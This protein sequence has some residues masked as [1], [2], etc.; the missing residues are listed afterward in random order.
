M[1]IPTW[2]NTV[3]PFSKFVALGLFAVLPFIGFVYGRHVEREAALLYIEHIE[4]AYSGSQTAVSEC[5]GNVKLV[6]DGY[7]N[8][9]EIVTFRG[10]LV[11]EK[12][13]EELALGDEWYWFYFDEPYLNLQSAS[14]GSVFEEKLQ[15]V[16]SQHLGKDLDD[17]IGKRVEV[18]AYMSWGYAESNT[19]VIIAIAEL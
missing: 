10:L 9:Y 6:D 16:P 17:F 5:S 1:K 19:V 2:A 8:Q 14:G 13:P 11:K 4:T 7:G 15:A 3:T 12:I 18:A